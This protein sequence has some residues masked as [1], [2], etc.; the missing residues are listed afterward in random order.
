M[1][2]APVAATGAERSQSAVS[3]ARTPRAREAAAGEA[4]AALR[5][6]HACRTLAAPAGFVRGDRRQEDGRAESA[7]TERGV[8]TR[9]AVGEPGRR[10]EFDRRL[11]ETG[12]FAGEPG[13]SIPRD[14]LLLRLPD[15]WQRPAAPPAPPIM[16]RNLVRATAAAR[17]SSTGRRRRRATSA[18]SC[19][20]NCSGFAREAGAVA[21]DD[22]ARPRRAATL[23]RR[24]GRARRTARAAQHGRGKGPRGRA[25]ARSTTI[26]GAGCS[27]PSHGS[28]QSE[29]ALTGVVDSGLVSIVIDRTFVDATGVRWIVDYKTSS[30][31]GAGLDEFLDNERE[32]YRGQLERYAQL[33]RVSAMSRSVSGCISRCCRR[34][35][36]GRQARRTDQSV[37]PTL[38]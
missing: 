24:T 35:A 27:Q 5:R 2:I 1:I 19:T 23:H 3:L 28:A 32:R 34:G 36:S 37:P 38:N 13:T 30:H 26:A 25:A 11:A 17:S 7:C 10:R 6:C 14:P 18:R 16:I 21:N 12:D 9:L 15:D 29:L 31:E 4:A 33:M 22:A 8:G 20:V